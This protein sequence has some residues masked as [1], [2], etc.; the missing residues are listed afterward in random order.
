[1]C[2]F[3]SCILCSVS[4]LIIEGRPWCRRRCSPASAPTREGRRTCWPSTPSGTW[5]VKSANFSEV[6][7]S[8]VF[9]DVRWS[10]KLFQVFLSIT[11]LMKRFFKLLFQESFLFRSLFIQVSL[12]CFRTS[13]KIISF[14]GECNCISSR[15]ELSWAGDVFF[16]DLCT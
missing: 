13:T 5:R 4:T 12:W 11:F 6:L 7:L 10:K 15:P 2:P 8:R 14:V 3:P 9:G 16:T 1:M